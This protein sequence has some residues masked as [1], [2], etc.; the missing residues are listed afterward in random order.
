[1][2]HLDH[3]LTLTTAWFGEGDFQLS[4]AACCSSKASPVDMTPWPWIQAL[5]PPSKPHSVGDPWEPMSATGHDHPGK[6]NRRPYW[7]VSSGIQAYQ[8]IIDWWHHTDSPRI[9]V[10]SI[11]R[12]WVFFPET[13]GC[14]TKAGGHP[15]LEICGCSP[16][17]EFS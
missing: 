8:W 11:Q 14:F 5:E 2:I 13:T 12:R 9:D 3:H 15:L 17:Q 10:I 4:S 16:L 7:L 1:M 6:K